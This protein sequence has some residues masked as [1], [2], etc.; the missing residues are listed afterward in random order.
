M[1]DSLQKE[2]QTHSR[3]DTIRLGLLNDLGWSYR[4]VDPAKGLAVADSAI[5]LGKELADQGR[6][7]SAYNTKAWNYSSLGRDSAAIPLFAGGLTIRERLKDSSGMAKIRY[8]IGIMYFN[9]SDYPRA[10]EYQQSALAFFEAKGDKIRMANCY[11]AIGLT[12][13]YVSDYPKALD[14]YLKTLAIYEKDGENTGL[15]ATL[16]NVGI[17]YKN[18]ENFRKALE[19]Q[20]KALA[21]YRESGD[22]QGMAN[23]LGN[24]GV[25][26]D[27][28]KQSEQSLSHYRQ[29]LAVARTIGFR[30]GIASNLA[31]IGALYAG[32]G[33]YGKAL[34]T[35]REALAIWKETGDKNNEGETLGEIAKVVAAAPAAVLASHGIDP[36][37]RY[38]HAHALLQRALA[39]AREI[40]SPG[41]QQAAW[42]YLGECYEKEKNFSAALEAYRQSLIFRDSISNT[43]RAKEI[44]RKELQFDFEKK[45][46]VLRAEND[47]QQALALAEI[48]R[49]R[50]VRNSILAGVALLFMAA[51]AVFI[52]YKNKRDAEYL[53]QT[54]EFRAEVAETEMK[55]LR[56]QMNP[57]FIFNSLNSI[58]DFI[59][60]NDSKAADLYLTKFAQ[61]MRLILENSEWREVSLSDDLKALEI[62]MQLE[63]LRL[64]HH[65]TYEIRVDDQ[66]DPEMTLV[67]PLILQPFVENS[68]WHGLP[69]ENGKGKILV[70]IRKEGEMILCTVEDNGPGLN[71]AGAKP[72]NGHRSLGVRITGSRI[73][74]LNK[75]RQKQ[76]SI[77]IT[78][79]AQGMKVEVKLPL[80]LRY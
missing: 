31:N 59:L 6:L 15:P 38:Q 47:K 14:C 78:D 55:A 65:F 9:L 51:L 45:Q 52:F 20:Q 17:L 77:A 71:H 21:I 28:L 23:A 37:H 66:I 63:S 33:E 26:Y 30:S 68:I 76:A 13:Q 11:N 3:R 19:Y 25:V 72:N 69:K 22:Q 54:A 62:Y 2:L 35:L 41:R 27:N 16:M 67:P 73:D 74:I 46:T 34:D 61:L 18:M 10:L 56:T 44:T 43:E 42:Q 32:L 12:Y 70:H 40:H 80:E 4:T 29:A 1:I 7:A 58:G 24:I 79:L 39:L 75:I 49:Q 48:N 5:A 57:H 8:N 36:N 50:V 60:K 64:N 53:R